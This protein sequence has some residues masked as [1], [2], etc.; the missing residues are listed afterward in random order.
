MDDYVYWNP[1]IWLGILILYVLP[2]CLCFFSCKKY[3]RKLIPSILISI[4]YPTIAWVFILSFLGA[5]VLSISLL[6]GL[7][8]FPEW[9]CVVLGMAFG[10]GIAGW[11]E[12]IL[13]HKIWLF[14]ENFKRKGVYTFK[15][16]KIY[17]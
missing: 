14:Y 7:E 4:A 12:A 6:K 3:K 1:P 13:V 10:G 5:I 11:I 2:M 17:D 8:F 9:I 15:N 16:L